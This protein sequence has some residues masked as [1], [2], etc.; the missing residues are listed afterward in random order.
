MSLA[1]SAFCTRESVVSLSRPAPAPNLTSWKYQ[2]L[3]SFE[4][5]YSFFPLMERTSGLGKSN[6]R[7]STFMQT[8]FACS[9]RDAFLSCSSLMTEVSCPCVLS[10]KEPDAMDCETLDRKEGGWIAS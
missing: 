2:P 3:M 7:S 5:V 6:H 4:G 9:R 10:T 8:S 1:A